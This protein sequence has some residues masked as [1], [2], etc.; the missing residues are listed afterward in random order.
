MLIEKSVNRSLLLNHTTKQKIEQRSEI[1]QFLPESLEELV[2]K[3]TINYNSKNLKTSYIIDIIHNLIFK[4]YYKGDNLFTLNA[5]VL[6]EKY[7][8]EN[9]SELEISSDE[10]IDYV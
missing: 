9:A 4:Y 5:T 2:N 10:E 6:K 3:K 1:L 8:K 7:T